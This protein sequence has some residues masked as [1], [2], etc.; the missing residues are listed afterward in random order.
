VT[1]REQDEGSQWDFIGKPG[2]SGVILGGFY[3]DGR[4]TLMCMAD[5]ATKGIWLTDPSPDAPCPMTR[6]EDERLEVN[7]YGTRAEFD[8]RG[9][10]LVG[11]DS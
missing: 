3:T 5:H 11:R 9:W 10:K 6:E 8:A 7:W 1:D 4:L 2:D